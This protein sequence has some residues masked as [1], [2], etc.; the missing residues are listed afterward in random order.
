[1]NINKLTSRFP[2]KFDNSWVYVLT[3]VRIHYILYT[4]TFSIMGSSHYGQND[5][6]L[7][8][9]QQINPLLIDILIFCETAYMY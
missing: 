6:Q 9:E 7:Q 1:M 4:F 2:T 3:K 8:Q 5:V